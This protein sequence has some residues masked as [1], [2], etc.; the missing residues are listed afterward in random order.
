MPPTQDHSVTAAA[1]YRLRKPS[2]Q[3]PVVEYDLDN[4]AD[5]LKPRAVALELA[6]ETPLIGCPRA[7]TTRS[8]PA[9]CASGTCRVDDGIDHVALAQSAPRGS[10]ERTAASGLR[11]RPH[12][13]RRTTRARGDTPRGSRNASGDEP[14]L[15]SQISAQMAGARHT[16]LNRLRP[17]RRGRATRR[18]RVAQDRAT[19]SPRRAAGCAHARTRSA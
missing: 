2:L 17:W 7:W 16:D 3:Q 5:G 8:R 13:P 14:W 4:R 9:R 11:Y 6:R 10:I 19:R 18:R 15:R 12:T 1:R